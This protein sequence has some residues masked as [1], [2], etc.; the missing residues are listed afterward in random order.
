MTNIIN[1]PSVD[2]KALGTEC[3]PVIQ[4]WLEKH[5]A[6]TVSADDILRA[7]RND[8]GG[9]EDWTRGCECGAEVLA[10]AFG[11]VEYFLSEKVHCGRAANPDKTIVNGDDWIEANRVGWCFS[12]LPPCGMIFEF[13]E[14]AQAEAFAAEV[15][16]RFGLDGRVFDDAEAAAKSHMY[17]WEQYPPVAH[18]DRARDG[19][20][21]IDRQTEKAF[22]KEFKKQF[23]EYQKFTKG[24]GFSEEQIKESA[25]SIA[26]E[27]LIQELAEKKFGGRFVGT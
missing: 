12:N 2:E 9:D 5:P 22:Q 25:E 14:M 6:V 18:I 21:T 3:L 4:A 19:G 20:L 11:N 27:I 7:T 8:W 26:V 10:R 16:R 17:P 13:K 15:K 23:K 1:L 24:D